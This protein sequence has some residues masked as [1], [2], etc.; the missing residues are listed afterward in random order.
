MEKGRPYTRMRWRQ[1][2][3]D[4]NIEPNMVEMT[5]TNPI[6]AA[7]HYSKYGQIGRHNRCRQESLDIEKTLGT[8][9]WSKRFNISIFAMNV[10]NV[11][12]AYQNITGTA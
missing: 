12:L 5:N 10:V 2:D 1:K 11:W 9:D 7:I 4:P 6:T 8:K 3:P